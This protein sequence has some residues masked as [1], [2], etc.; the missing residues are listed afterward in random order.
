M[1]KHLD[2]NNLRELVVFLLIASVI[3]VPAFLGGGEDAYGQAIMMILLFPLT[4]FSFRLN[5][6]T[7][8]HYPLI[9]PFGIFL[10]TAA[11]SLIWS[12]SF[13]NSLLEIMLWISYFFIFFAACQYHS[14]FLKIRRFTHFIILLAVILSLIG[15]YFYVLSENYAALR[16]TSTFDWHNAFGGFL[17]MVL[18]L[19]LLL[20]LFAK[21]KKLMYAYGLSLA[22]T[23]L[24]LVFTFS[25]GSWLSFFISLIPLS[26]FFRSLLSLSVVFRLAILIMA[27]TFFAIPI[28][29]FKKQQILINNAGNASLNNANNTS[30]GNIEEN[31]VTARLYYFAGAYEIFKNYPLLGTGF[32]TFSS[33]HRQY[34]KDIRFYSSDPHNFYLKILSELGITGL[35]VLLWLIGTIFY[36][37]YSLHG[38]FHSASREHLAFLIY[39]AG[40]TGGII[41][42]LTH[43]GID[44]DWSFSANPIIFWILT[45][46]IL[47]SA[48]LLGNQTEEPKN[49]PSYFL[50]LVVLTT[51]FVILVSGVF[52]F[53]ANKKFQEAIFFQNSGRAYEAE[54]LYRTSIRYNP[55]EPNYRLYL[56][57]LN[58]VIGEKSE[59][60]DEWYEKA[61]KE[62]SQSIRYDSRNFQAHTLLAKILLSQNDFSGAEN[63]L[64]KSVSISPKENLDPFLLLSS[65][66]YQQ[67]KFD[68]IISL[69]IPVLSNYSPELFKS[70]L[71]SSSNPALVKKNVAELY[72]I[73]GKTYQ[74]I[75]D[76]QNS[77]K[78][79]QEALKYEP[80]N[81]EAKNTLN[82]LLK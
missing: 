61:K 22:I 73:L 9:F 3:A 67:K 27:V 71:W 57:Y 13:Y 16:L 17:I 30:Q 2:I 36:Y 5:G 59:N 75:N 82:S 35:A 42:A 72:V 43:N 46:I 49:P 80:E 44:V 6:E 38:F 56:G 74:T 11:A 54:K 77:T 24:A 41:A 45:G 76:G 78:S 51:A 60:K 1:D 70:Q 37:L 52:I 25:R 20:F 26:Y 47:S 18:P 69:L 28:H 12:P 48:K 66:Y 33:F 81:W 53:F 64:K 15:L 62:F 68:K 40:L 8:I 19:A 10:L 79:F 29:S 58:M 7:G 50:K 31:S 21:T 4:F 63:E 32:N 23:S 34:Q 55:I 65:I 14:T 39:P